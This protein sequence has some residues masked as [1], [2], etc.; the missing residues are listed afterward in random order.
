[1]KRAVGIWL[2]IAADVVV[3]AIV[4]PIDWVIGRWRDC[5]GYR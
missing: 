4:V 5:R 3:A 2:V 1:M